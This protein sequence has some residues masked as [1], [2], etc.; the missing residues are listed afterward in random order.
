MTTNEGEA[1]FEVNCLTV[2][3]RYYILESQVTRIFSSF[4]SYLFTEFGQKIYK[5]CPCGIVSYHIYYK[6]LFFL[7]FFRP[8]RDTTYYAT[9]RDNF[10]SKSRSHFLD[11]LRDFT[12][13]LSTSF[14][15]SIY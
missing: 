10:L 7:R 1:H 14:Q 5:V 6:S 3:I 13:Y 4:L 11:Y 9:I 15:L 2:G 8:R 12:F